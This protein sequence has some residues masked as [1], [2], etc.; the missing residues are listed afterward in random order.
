V[1][2]ALIVSLLLADAS[3]APTPVPAGQPAASTASFRGAWSADACVQQRRQSWD[4]YWYW[5]QRFYNGKDGWNAQSEMLV[6]KIADPATRAK[7]AADLQA[8]GLRVSAEWSKTNACRKIRTTTGI[9]NMSER[10]KP[11]LSTWGEEL[12]AAAKR[13]NGDGTALGAAID[14]LTRRVDALLG[15]PR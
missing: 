12:R 2:H 9:F 11:A 15:P 14:E 3:P 10:G 8:L 6:A 4:D 7:R 13:D 1:L 5:V